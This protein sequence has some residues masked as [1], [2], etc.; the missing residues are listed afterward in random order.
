LYGKITAG[1]IFG[2]NRFP[3]QRGWGELDRGQVSDVR[4]DA[5]SVSGALYFIKRDLWSLLTHCELYQDVQPVGEKAIGAFLETK[6]YFEETFASL[7][8]RA[9]GYKCVYYG[10]VK[11][12][13]HWHKSV[14]TR[15]GW[16][17]EQF[18][19]SQA[20]HREACQHHGIESE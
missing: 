18:K 14:E 5:I 7:H 10:P 3:K 8:A 15:T 2:S 1:G 9:H 13:H 12:I 19:I 11:M 6:L 16:G 4:D 17:E 20:M